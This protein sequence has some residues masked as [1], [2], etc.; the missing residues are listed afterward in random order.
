MGLGFFL[1]GLIIGL[2]LAIPV[3]P[4]G[5]LCIRRTLARGRMSGLFSGL[6]AATADGM[7]G[8]VA[9]FGLTFVSRF[10]VSHEILLRVAGGA[11]LCYLG[12]RIFVSKL[13]EKTNG[14]QEHGLFRDFASTLFL[15]LTNPLTILAFA[16]GFATLGVAEVPRQ[17]IMAIALILGVFTGST[18]WWVILSGVVSLLHKR[19]DPKGLRIVNK[20]SGTIVSAFGMM[21]LLSILVARP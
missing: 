18:L 21:V 15:T 3:G 7:Y 11:F 2:S 9:G 16:A 12:G 8:A 13:S 10:L 5:L 1:K 19:I 4:I 6:G 20:V 17:D 14:V